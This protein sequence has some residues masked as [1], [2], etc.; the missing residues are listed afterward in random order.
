G[1]GL[2][3]RV[4]GGGFRGVGG[5][6]RVGVFLA[7]GFLV[8]RL[9]P[10]GGFRVVLCG[11]EVEAAEVAKSLP[12]VWGRHRRWA[13]LRQRLAGAAYWGELFASPALWFAGAGL[14]AP[15][16]PPVLGA[17]ARLGP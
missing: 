5:R 7:E 2:S 3:F 13:I 12:V 14:S 16:A 17:A 15:G 4:S 11:E 6:G 9:V 1:L 8:G 10:R